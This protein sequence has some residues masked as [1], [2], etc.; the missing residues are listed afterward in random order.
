MGAYWFLYKY[1]IFQ[2]ATAT[3]VN[4]RA[5]TK[6][7]DPA[8]PLARLSAG[9]VEEKLLDRKVL[10]TLLIFLSLLPN[11]SCFC[12]T[13]RHVVTNHT[14]LAGVEC[15]TWMQPSLYADALLPSLC[16]ILLRGEDG[17]QFS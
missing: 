9:L 15:Q 1:D 3:M 16:C 14:S 5:T 4:M 7:D 6:F 11:P 12:L 10:P 2:V 17:V 13:V 8:R